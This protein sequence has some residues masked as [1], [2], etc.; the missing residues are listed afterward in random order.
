[1]IL[2]LAENG[3]FLLMEA[4]VCAGSATEGKHA[5]DEQTKVV[6]Q[7]TYNSAIKLSTI[8]MNGRDCRMTQ[9][10]LLLACEF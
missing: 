3:P 9:F 4:T 7:S 8:V 10:G 6:V 5:E 1:M 2:S